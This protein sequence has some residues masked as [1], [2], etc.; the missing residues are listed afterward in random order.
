MM[1]PAFITSRLSIRLL[2]MM[3]IMIVTIMMSPSS[4]SDA[5]ELTELSPA[6]G[7]TFEKDEEIRI[8]CDYDL[9]YRDP[10]TLKQNGIDVVTMTYSRSSYKFL[11]KSSIKGFTCQAPLHTS[12]IWCT[13]KN[14]TCSDATSYSCSLLG[15]AVSGQK[16]LTVRSGIKDVDYT[17]ESLNFNRHSGYLCRANTG[18]VPGS[19]VTFE[20][21]VVTVAKSYDGTIK[22]KL[23]HTKEDEITVP[24]ADKCYSEISSFYS[25]IPLRDVEFFSYIECSVF[26]Q[27]QVKP[28]DRW[29]KRRCFSGS[30]VANSK[31]VLVVKLILLLLVV[32]ISR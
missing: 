18:L 12:E 5:I 20:W 31:W 6:D 13:K 14:T 2:I 11:Q 10:I 7:L 8:T 27:T 4:T 30:G 29:W 32:V 15:I 9:G 21:K 22:K 23:I 16:I 26:G 3:M 19:T 1:S 28:N 24:I 25:C 17:E